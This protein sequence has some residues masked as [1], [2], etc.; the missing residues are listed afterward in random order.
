MISALLALLLA[1]PAAAAGV[2][3][4]VSG[5]TSALVGAEAGL[6]YRPATPPGAKLE[7]DALASATTD[8]AVVK[9]EARPDGAW[10]WTLLPLD[11]GTFDFVARWTLDGKPVSAPPATLVARAP[12]L[13][14]DV[15][16]EDIKKPIAARR[17]LWP[18]LLA[19]ALGALAWE[20]WRRWK[21]RPRPEGLAAAA[22]PPPPPEAAAEKALAEL[23][24][25]QLW[26]RGEHAAFYL[27][28]TDILRAYLE[29]RYGEPAS[30]MTSVEVARLVKSREPDLKASAAVR[31]LLGR[32]DLVKF[33]RFKP[34]AD[35]GPRDIQTTLGVVR[36]TTPRAATPAPEAA[37]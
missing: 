35:E 27:R 23:G 30:A 2:S 31:E 13:P 7:P 17:A 32:A 25:S 28:L 21:S 9:V 24:A 1:A 33:A 6:V 26:E 34:A 20:G 29:A 22:E 3:W 10:A 37:R 12:D 14:K 15:D 19:A 4:Q 16:I 8:F 18:W 11:E 5:D 36:A